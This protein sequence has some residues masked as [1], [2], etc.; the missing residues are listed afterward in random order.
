[1]AEQTLATNQLQGLNTA[2]IANLQKKHG[3]N[4]FKKDGSYNFLR[5]VVDTVK[6]PMFILLAVACF[7]YFLLGEISEGIMMLVA[8]SIVSAISLYQEVKSSKALEALKSFAEPLVEVIRSGKQETIAA[9]ELVPGDVMLLAE[10]MNVPADARVV[11][12]NDLSVNESV[13]TGESV[14]VTKTPGSNEDSLFQ[15]TTINSGKC[16]AVVTATGN[17]TALGKLGKMIAEYAPPKTLLQQQINTFVKRLA[18]FGLIAFAII[19]LVNYLHYREWTAS[20]LFALTLAMSALPEEIPVAFSSFMALGAFKMSKLGIISRQ[21]AVVENLG[22]VTVL[23]FDKTGTLTENRMQVKVLYDYKTATDIAFG[24]G[25]ANGK[26]ILLYGALASE[27]DPFDA[28]EQAIWQAYAMAGSEQDAAAMNMVNEFP[29]EGQPPMMTHVYANGQAKMVAGK[30]AA[31]RIVNACKL[32]IAEQSAILAKVKALALQGYRVIGVASAVYN[33][34]APMPLRQDDF[35][36]QFEGLIALFDPPKQN[37]AAILQQFYQAGIQVKLI[38]GD[39]PET[40]MNIAQQVGI[41]GT[42]TFLTGAL[43]QDMEE[44]VLREKIK[45]VQVFARM[46]PEAKLKVVN[47][48]KA[49]GDIVAMTGDG[50][51]DGPALRSSNIGIAMGKKGTEL[52]KEAADLILTDDNLEKITFAIKEG[53]KIFNNLRKAVRYI[54][55]IHVPIILTASLPVVFGWQY[56]NIFTPIH[57]IFMELIM[58]PTCSIFFEREPVEANIMQQ[59]PRAKSNR[60]F[61]GAE[62]MVSV[63]QGLVIAAGALCVYY[64]AMHRGETLEYTR[65]MVFTTLVIS[66]LLLTF[67]NRSFTQS[68]IVTSRYANNLALP[69]FAVSAVF[70][71]CMHFVQPVQHLFKLTAISGT[72]FFT[73]LLVAVVSVLWFEVY[74]Y[75]TGTKK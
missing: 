17:N 16:V 42:H 11:E 1:M 51:N 47:A 49:N 27:K 19:F 66:N 29:L 55:S 57:V 44:H 52:A 50:V 36:W 37:A 64:F 14:P 5:I 56:P 13:L 40:A 74:K 59:P 35:D 65:T 45:D 23:C 22:A 62:L 8:I 4:V 73:C 25:T 70:L 33:N 67:G 15:G 69:V 43:V 3:K 6:E 60:L 54:I 2:D 48:L 58:G 75:F 72:A 12:Q 26:N 20:L 41:N 34:D 38:T 9:E 24:E 68:I 21:P 32:T 61:N 7:L 10:G 63:L 18:F 31:E 46:F 71:L 53:R 30:G 28:M 39:Y